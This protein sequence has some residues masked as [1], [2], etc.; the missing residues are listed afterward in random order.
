M[1]EYIQLDDTVRFTQNFYHPASGYSSA[2]DSTPRYYVYED[3]TNTNILQ[4]GMTAR[5]DIPGSYHGSFVASTANGFETDKFYDVQVSGELNGISGFTSVKQFKLGDIYDTNVVQV[6]GEPITNSTATYDA[7]VV[8]VSGEN[9]HIDNF[10]ADVSNLDTTVSSR[11]PTTHIDA[12]AG[13]VDNVTL[14][15]TTTDVTNNVGVDLSTLESKLDSNGL[16]LVAISGDTINILADTNELQANQGNW[17]TAVGFSTHSA[18]DVADLVNP[19]IDSASGAIMDNIDS[20]ND[21]D[22]DNDAV[23]NVT[24][25][26]T[27]TTNTDM[28]GTDNAALSSELTSL[29]SHGDSTWSTATGF[30]TEEQIM[31]VSGAIQDTLSTIDN[32]I[33]YANI[34]YVRDATNDTD[35]FAVH[36]FKNDQPVSSGELTSPAISVYNTNNGS[37]L[38]QHQLMSYASSNLGV[39]RHNETP[40]VM[41]SGEP[42][43]VAVSGTID[44]QLKTW[45]SIIGLDY[46]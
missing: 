11:M 35:E 21:F 45:K 37:A 2:V 46:I 23:A 40:R 22:P 6:S 16:Y 44:A 15:D 34:K 29:E 7:N 27:V 24:L 36:W 42:Y 5:T 10:K 33:Y 13:A 9:V 1:S 8:S 32:D 38:I 30:S 4:G 31:S 17:L 25:V 12:T 3:D 26:D 43:L 39:V 19:N 41:A 28:R 14:V 18:S 20:L